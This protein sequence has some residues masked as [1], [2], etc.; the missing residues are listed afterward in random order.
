MAYGDRYLIASSKNSWVYEGRGS[1]KLLGYPT[2]LGVTIGVA[3]VYC[4]NLVATLAFVHWNV[5]LSQGSP[6]I[7]STTLCRLPVLL[8]IRQPLSYLSQIAFFYVYRFSRILF[9][10]WSANTIVCSIM[11]YKVFLKSP[12]IST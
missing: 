11:R 4:G 1:Y 12:Y 2:D 5:K 3:Y 7:P 9:F 6:R 10:D 8:S